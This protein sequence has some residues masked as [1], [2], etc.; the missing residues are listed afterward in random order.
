MS[1]SWFAMTREEAERAAARI[2]AFWRAR[3]HDAGARVVKQ[4]VGPERQR[5]HTYGI[6]SDLINGLPRRKSAR[7]LTAIPT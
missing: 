7:R 1:N 5:K 6:R 2:N 4:P 3:G